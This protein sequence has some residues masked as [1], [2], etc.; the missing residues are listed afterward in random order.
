MLNKGDEV[1]RHNCLSQLPGGGIVHGIDHGGGKVKS[2]KLF[3]NGR[4]QAVRLPQDCR[5][6]GTEVYIS[7]YDGLVILMSKKSPWTSLVRSLSKFSEDFMEER[8]QPAS[9]SRESIP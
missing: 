4:S 9:Q 6:D 8:C 1:I 7:R 2:A 5:F 3:A